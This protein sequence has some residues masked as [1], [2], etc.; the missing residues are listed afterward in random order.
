MDRFLKFG[1]IFSHTS[2][3]LIL[4]FQ[5]IFEAIIIYNINEYPESRQIDAGELL[6]LKVIHKNCLIR[7][8]VSDI[9]VR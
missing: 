2:I 9:T 7:I 8:P 1:G 4:N 5:Q 3:N 6:V